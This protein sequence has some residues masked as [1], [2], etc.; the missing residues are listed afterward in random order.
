[1][2]SV[3]VAAESLW[4]W[5][6]IYLLVCGPIL[7]IQNFISYLFTFGVIQWSSTTHLDKNWSDI[8]WKSP[9]RL[10]FSCLSLLTFLPNCMLHIFYFYSVVVCSL[11][12]PLPLWIRKCNKMIQ[13]LAH[14]CR[15]LFRDWAPRAPGFF[16]FQVLI[17][18]LAYQN[19]IYISYAIFTVWI[20][21]QDYK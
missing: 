8:L 7:F 9:T 13:W 5:P 6:K 2:L 10:N 16:R 4:I 20:K 11:W 1:M 15:S 18:D 14:V 19:T 3:M 17:L 21:E 12:S